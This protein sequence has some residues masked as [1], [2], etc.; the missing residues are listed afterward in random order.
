ML[1][2]SCKRY[3]EP[4]GLWTT[5]YGIHFGIEPRRILR[6]MLSC[7]G[8][9]Y[10]IV[11][12]DERTIG[13]AVVWIFRNEMIMTSHTHR[14]PFGKKKARH[15]RTTS[16]VLNDCDATYR[17]YGRT[18]PLTPTA[19]HSRNSSKENIHRIACKVRGLQNSVVQHPNICVPLEC[20][21][22]SW[23]WKPLGF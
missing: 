8:I 7:N 17:T 12:T 15:K 11:V 9:I 4:Q 22:I 16:T 23:I 5:R 20:Y 21:W 6:I 3:Q 2:E 1:L 14:W 13:V 10:I 19:P 18:F